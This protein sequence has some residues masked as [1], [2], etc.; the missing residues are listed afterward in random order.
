MSAEEKHTNLRLKP[1]DERFPHPESLLR[2]E[3]EGF[4]GSLEDERY[5]REIEEQ[6]G[7]SENPYFNLRLRYSENEVFESKITLMRTK[8]SRTLWVG[9]AIAASLALLVAIAGLH[10]RYSQR[11]LARATTK[12]VKKEA[13]EAVAQPI[14]VD[15]ERRTATTLPTATPDDK[16]VK[17]KT[18][19]G[20]DK[21]E[22]QETVDECIVE[23][24]PLLA[25]VA[26][27]PKPIKISTIQQ[28]HTAILEPTFSPTIADSEPLSIETIAENVGSGIKEE[29]GIDKVSDKLE[30]WRA[31]LFEQSIVRIGMVFS[32]EKVATVTKEYNSEGE[33]TSYSIKAGIISRQR[34]YNTEE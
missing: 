30:K 27:L 10:T 17:Q 6:K 11:E 2:S 3:L 26:P 28:D 12:C 29:L 25:E 14:Q 5:I 1:T 9:M 16:R 19:N 15:S 33:L 20:I 31:K 34:S 13:K 22:S 24:L 32:K 23:R 8:T 7:G 4:D 18:G 21:Y